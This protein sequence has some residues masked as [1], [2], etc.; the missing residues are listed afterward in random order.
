M[1]QCRPMVFGHHMRKES[2]VDDDGN[3]GRAFGSGKR[4]LV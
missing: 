2:L 1:E 3:V 4:G